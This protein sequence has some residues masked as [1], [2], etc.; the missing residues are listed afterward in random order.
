MVSIEEHT[1]KEAQGFTW[2]S[3][4]CGIVNLWFDEKVVLVKS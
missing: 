1:V 3:R 4:I 2:R